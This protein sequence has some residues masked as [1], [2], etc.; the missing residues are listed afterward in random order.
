MLCCFQKDK[1][2]KNKKL[3]E[4]LAEEEEEEEAVET[5]PEVCYRFQS[6]YAKPCLS[7]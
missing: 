7:A 1:K 5:E 4:F 2:S 3:A 6:V